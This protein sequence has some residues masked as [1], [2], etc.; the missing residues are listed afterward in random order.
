MWH[1]PVVSLKVLKVAPVLEFT[2]VNGGRYEPA[3]ALLKSQ[4]ASVRLEDTCFSTWGPHE[5][6]RRRFSLYK[7]VT[8]KQL[9]TPP[10]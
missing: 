1:R 5:L 6:S 8:H 2:A 4:S 3:V 10:V 7:N 9:Q